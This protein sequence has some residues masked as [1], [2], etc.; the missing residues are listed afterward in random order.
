MRANILVVV[1]S[2]MLIPLLVIVH[3]F[4]RGSYD[5]LEFVPAFFEL[6]I[7]LSASG[8]FLL[9]TEWRAFA[10]FLLVFLRPLLPVLDF[11]IAH[12]RL[13]LLLL[14]AIVGCAFGGGIREGSVGL[15]LFLI[16]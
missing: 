14:F 13:G 10:S 7:F 8:L 1:L 5:R 6:E 11:I 16:H 15:F 12:E 3:T 4:L 9:W 2:N